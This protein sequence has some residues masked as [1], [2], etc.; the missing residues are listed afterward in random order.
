M[1]NLQCIK[2]KPLKIIIKLATTE[3]EFKTYATGECGRTQKVKNNT[4][5]HF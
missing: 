1:N 3:L 4:T 5:S 2:T